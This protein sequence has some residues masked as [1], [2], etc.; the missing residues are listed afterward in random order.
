[1]FQYKAR[2]IINSKKKNGL[3][4]LASRSYKQMPDFLKLKLFTHKKCPDVFMCNPITAETRFSHG[5]NVFGITVFYAVIHVRL[6][7]GRPILHR[8]VQIPGGTL[9]LL[10]KSQQ[11]PDLR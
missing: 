4:F 11:C 10:R 9:I 3:P 6:F 5:Y 8:F 1:M 2:T 7:P